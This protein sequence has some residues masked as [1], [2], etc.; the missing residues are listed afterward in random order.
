MTLKAPAAGV[1]LGGG[2]SIMI[3][4]PDRDK[5]E[6]AVRAHGRFIA[7]LGVASFRSTMWAVRKRI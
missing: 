6:D 5:T 2:A 3:G 7:T 4:H 1:D